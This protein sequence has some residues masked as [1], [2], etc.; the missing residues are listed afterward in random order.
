MMESVNSR[1]VDEFAFGQAFTW[2]KLARDDRVA[3]PLEHLL[4]QGSRCLLDLQL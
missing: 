3:Q 4:A 1:E 2:R